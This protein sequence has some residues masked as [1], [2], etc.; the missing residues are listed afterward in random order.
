MERLDRALDDIA[1]RFGSQA[2]RR[3]KVKGAKP[4]VRG[5]SQDGKRKK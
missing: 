4:A 3:G 2:V 1:R 5:E